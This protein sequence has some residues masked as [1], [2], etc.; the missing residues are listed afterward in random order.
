M[1]EGGALALEPYLTVLRGRQLSRQCA[2]RPKNLRVE[3]MPRIVRRHRSNELRLGHGMIVY[4]GVLFAFDG[5][6]AAITVGDQT[7]LNRDCKLI[8]RQ[9]VTIGRNCQIGWDVSITDSDFHQVVGGGPVTAPVT[10]GDHVWLGARVTV[11]KGVTIGDG[12]IVAAGAVVTTDVAPATMVG[13]VP[14]RLLKSGV[15]WKN[16]HA[17]E[18]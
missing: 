1:G 12:A 16:V 6:E 14:A 10:I 8:A 4:S 13:G 3:Q 11:L 18:H 2:N 17:G 9:A 5:P 7:F 15:A